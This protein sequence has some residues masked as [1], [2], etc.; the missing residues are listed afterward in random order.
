MR[1]HSKAKRLLDAR[2]L[3]THEGEQAPVHDEVCGV[4]RAKDACRC[5]RPG[6]GASCINHLADHS[7]FPCRSAHDNLRDQYQIIEILSVEK[8]PNASDLGVF[9]QP[10]FRATH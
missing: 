1:V 2:R 7:V 3:L 8:Q 6:E 10:T 9:V 4:A 5:S